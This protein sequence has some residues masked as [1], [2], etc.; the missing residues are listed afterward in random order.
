MAAS[1]STAS[2]LRAVLIATAIAGALGYAVQLLAP[3]LLT[4]ESVY[5]AFSVFWSTIYLGVSAMSG[6]QQEVTRAAHPAT[7]EPPSAVLRTFALAAAGLVVLA[8]ALVALL[9]GTRILPGPVVVTG[10]V[11][12]IGLVGYLAVAVLSGVLYGLRF[13]RD[14]AGIMVLDAAIRAV[15]LIAGFTVG[16]P[17]EWLALLVALPFGLAFG[18]TWLVVR[19]RVVGRFRLDVPLRRFAAHAWGTVGAAAASGV[20]ITGLPMLIGITAAG[21]PPETLG[22]LLLTITLT[23]APIVIPI[24]ALQSFLISAVFRG[25][26]VR[27]GRLLQVLALLLAAVAVLAVIAGFI[28]PPIVSWV[29]AGRFTIDGWMVGVI[30]LSAGLVG[31]MSVTS[32]ALISARRHTANFVG[33]LVAAV[34]TVGGLII[35]IAG[36]S[37]IAIA[38]TVPAIVGLVIH[39]VS[40]TRPGIQH[41]V[42]GGGSPDSVGPGGLG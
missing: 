26:R 34:L 25:G 5:V 37:R 31:A 28:G 4:D 36:P 12:A 7:N 17:I 18:A 29:S 20:L 41:D 33:W 15:L 2:G 35:P 23:R 1:D 32:P 3:A 24:I 16:L 39:V 8:S 27:P 30:V 14:I 42:H 10:A 6:V 21:T 19:R 22:A 40:L 9:F 38:L 13:W 11:L